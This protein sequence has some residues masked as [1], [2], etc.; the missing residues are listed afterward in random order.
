MIW[1][2]IGAILGALQLG[3]PLMMGKRVVTMPVLYIGVGAALGAGV[4]GTILWL[5]T[6]WVF[7]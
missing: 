1:F 3:I 6:S 5:V 7:G 2:I 4:Y